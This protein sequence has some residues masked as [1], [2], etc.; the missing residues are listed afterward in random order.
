MQKS[1][2]MNYN[3]KTIPR[4]EKDLKHLSKKYPSLKAEYISTKPK[5]IPWATIVIKYAWPLPLRVKA[6]EVGQGLLLISKW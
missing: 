4:F 5:A 3:V 6:K 1:Y 2:S